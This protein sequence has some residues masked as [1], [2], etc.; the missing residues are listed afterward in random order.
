MP[1]DKDPRA[2]GY[3][4]PDFR[5]GRTL[6]LE[7]KINLAFAATFRPD[8]PAAMLVLDYLRAAFVNDVMPPNAPD[9][10]LRHH[11][12]QRDLARIIFNRIDHGRANLPAV[13]ETQQ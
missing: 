3:V 4:P 11:E 2:P 12:G 10:Q 5:P 13:P 7:S 8:N 1:T 6:D 9:A